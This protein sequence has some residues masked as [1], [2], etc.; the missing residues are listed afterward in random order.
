MNELLRWHLNRPLLNYAWLFDTSAQTGRASLLP[1]PWRHRIITLRMLSPRL[2]TANVSSGVFE[3]L[4]TYRLFVDNKGADIRP[5][6]AWC[7]SSLLYA[8]DIIAP[9]SSPPTI[10][11]LHPEDSAENIRFLR[12]LSN[13]LHQG[14]ISF[15]PFTAAHSCSDIRSASMDPFPTILANQR[16]RQYTMGRARKWLTSSQPITDSLI[17]PNLEPKE[18][19]KLWSRVFNKMLPSK[20]QVLIWR[21]LPGVAFES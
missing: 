5:T 17:L 11:K 9:N 20:H 1:S 21:C 16:L 3:N 13:G 18:L 14:K 8:A 6:M 2:D 12:L 10:R 15:A 7:R 4:P 19:P